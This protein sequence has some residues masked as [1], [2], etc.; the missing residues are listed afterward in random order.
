MSAR[1]KLNVA[2]F[3]GCLFVSVLFGLAAQ[4]WTIFW[5]AIAVTAGCGVY[6]GEIRPRTGRR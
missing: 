1:N 2:Y 3:N 6:S 4:S 5:I